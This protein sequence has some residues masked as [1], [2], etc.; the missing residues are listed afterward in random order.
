M[1]AIDPRSVILLTGFVGV[2]MA[3]VLF[4]VG[5]SYPRTLR[6]LGQW[7]AATLA[8]VI[9]TALF[10]GRGY[11]PD[12]LT[13]VVANLALLTCYMLFYLGAER[14]YDLPP[15][16][17]LCIGIF[18]AMVPLTIAV[19]LYQPH[20]GYRVGLTSSSL[21]LTF[22]AL[23]RLLWVHGRPNFPTR[24]TLSIVV[25]QTVILATRAIWGIGLP[26]NGE[27]FDKSLLQAVYLSSF[28]LVMASVPIGLI[29][30]AADRLRSEFEYMASHDMLTGILNRRA[31]IDA[32]ESELERSRRHG[33]TLTVMLID[34]DHFKDINDQY[35]HLIGD[36]VLVDFARRSG[37]LL[38]RPDRMGRYGG[39]EF[40]VLLPETGLPEAR[41]VAERILAAPGDAEGL[42]AY[43]L[44]IG[45]TDSR[46]TDSNV[47]SLLA[48]A[49]VALYR[50]KENGRNR[51]ESE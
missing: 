21:G 10:A 28:A 2:M 12:V 44:S 22:F 24:F 13:I 50:A 20:Y 32:T 37:P 31:I 33:H 4:F 41:V 36:A 43:A 47:D 42:P 49:D 16:D 1:L 38:R 30:M 26:D 3:L 19:G 23:A 45:L 35:G 11:L 46:A 48:R 6:G 25:L 34:L 27:L 18:C 8:G 39:E 7:T 17:R 29:L 51:I 9:A 40:I 14:F 5:R 15:S